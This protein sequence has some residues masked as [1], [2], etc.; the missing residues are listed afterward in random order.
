MK[1]GVI[2]D[3]HGL[4]RDSALQ[5]LAG[6]ELILHG[7]DVGH[8]RVF[9]ALRPIAPLIVVTGNVD[10]PGWYP[11]TAE[12]ELEEMSGFMVHDIADVPARP[13]YDIVITGHS[14]KWKCERRGGV[15]YLNPGAAGPR[16]FNLPITLARLDVQGAKCDVERVELG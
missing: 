6:C 11:E 14:H 15:L 4:V 16:R 9:E 5:A 13:Q 1:V 10:A 3:T 2:S 12:F 8:V 7:G